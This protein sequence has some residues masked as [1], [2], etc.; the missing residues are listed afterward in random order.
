MFGV[1]FGKYLEEKGIL[2]A[3]QY[4]S[5]IEECKTSKVKLGL[6]AVEEGA[7]T[8]EQAEEV[9]MLQQMQDRRFGDIAVDKG[10][11]TE[12]QVST[13]LERQGDEYLLFVQALNEHNI[14]T[15]DQI[16]K[17]I[18]AYKKAKRMTALDIEAL[19]SGDIDRIVP[20]FVKGSSVHPLVKDYVALTARDFVRFI[21]TQFRIE[22][23]EKLNEFK[24]SYVAGQEMDGDYN[25]FTGYCG[26]GKGI[27]IIAER[28]AKETFEDIDAD[29]LDAACE[30]LNCNNGLF[31]TKLGNE[32]VDMDMLPPL[33]RDSDTTI[34][35]EGEMYKVP[36]YIND[37][38]VDLIICIEAKW[39]FD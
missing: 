28:Y 21:D 22:N 7:M 15:L 38:E 17:E 35:S 12:D 36:F 6:L 23:I 9:N 18:N 37:A 8:T 5:V 26:D 30:F 33:M 39:K 1:Y 24:T 20:V 29:V 27:K 16:Q 4:Q 10:Y 34:S 19:K 2:T 32:D 11:L 14:L 31:A 13:L 25:M 3:E